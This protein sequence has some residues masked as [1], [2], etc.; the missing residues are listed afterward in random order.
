MPMAESTRILAI[1]GLG[2]FMDRYATCQGTYSGKLGNSRQITLIHQG[3]IDEA[4]ALLRVPY[5][6]E[7]TRRNLL[8]DGDIDLLELIGKD[9]LVGPVL[10]RGTEECLPCK[11]PS[12]MTGKEN[13]V[14]AFVG[15]GG[16]RAELLSTGYISVNDKLWPR[17][18]MRTK[19]ELQQVAV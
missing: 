14:N 12:Q 8:I 1:I 3:S 18:A 15:K 19:H 16:I 11:I 17:L 7:E 2:L 10:M 4:N 9:F 5:T 13:F 6:V